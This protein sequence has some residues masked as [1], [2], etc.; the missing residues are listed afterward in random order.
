MTTKWSPKDPADIADYKL[1]WSPFLANGETIA[2]KTVTVEAGLTKVSDTITDSNTSVTIRLSGGT[3]GT[4]YDVT[5]LI[6]TSMGQTFET[7][8]P[9]KVKNRVGKLD[10]K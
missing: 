1:D 8:K 7:T 4:D 6:T 10:T 2:T 9:L 5:C 3:D